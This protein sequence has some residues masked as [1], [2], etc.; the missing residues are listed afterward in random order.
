MGRRAPEAE[1]PSPKPQRNVYGEVPPET[2]AVNVTVWPAVG[3]DGLKLKLADKG[4]GPVTLIGCC[5]LA[6]C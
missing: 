5:E 3:E 1:P 6:V 4:C 2:E